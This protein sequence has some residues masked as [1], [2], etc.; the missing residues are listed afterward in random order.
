MADCG[1]SWCRGFSR[2]IP[3]SWSLLEA[4]DRYNRMSRIH[5]PA[6]LWLDRRCGA[7]P[8]SIEYRPWL[9]LWK[10]RHFV[11]ADVAKV[12]HSPKIATGFHNVGCPITGTPRVTRRP[13]ITDSES[14]APWVSLARKT[15]DSHEFHASNS[16]TVYPG[17]KIWFRKFYQT[18]SPIQTKPDPN[19]TQVNSVVHRA[20]RVKSPRFN[21]Y[22]FL[23]WNLTLFHRIWSPELPQIDGRWWLTVT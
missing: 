11:L 8:P 3:V 5:Y 12:G 23:V 6:P 15:N 10:R 4:D 2:P 1:R 19:L 16:T 20:N 9:W 7:L 13:L 17:F 22:T 18:I 14:T 21:G